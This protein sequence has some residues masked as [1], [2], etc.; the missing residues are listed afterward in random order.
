MYIL[1]FTDDGLADVKNLPKNVRNAL[2]KVLRD[3][4]AKDPCTCSKPLNEPLKGYR[5]FTWED[6][7]I[8]Y[9]VFEDLKAVAVV[10]IGQRDAQSST[11]V[12]KR[13]EVL[14]EGGRLAEKVLLSLRGF[15]ES[16]P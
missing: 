6:Y 15:S 9:R 3:N 10:G 14:A 2:R 1:K 12:Y 11:N 16:G 8:I 4:V 13:L 7:R 5:S